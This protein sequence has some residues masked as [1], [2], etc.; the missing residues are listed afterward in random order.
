[1]KTIKVKLAV[2]IRNLGGGSAAPCFFPN[3]R[4]A[5][6]FAQKDNDRF[7]DDIYER[8]IE[9]DQSGNLV[10]GFPGDWVV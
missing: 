9:V 2:Y 4:E 7:C 3:M 8:V 5:E 1:M 10:S 6:L